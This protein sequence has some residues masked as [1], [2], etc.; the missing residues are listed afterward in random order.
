[1]TPPCMHATRRLPRQV[2][3]VDMRLV[4]RLCGR[5]APRPRIVSLNPFSLEDVL[6]VGGRGERRGD[7]L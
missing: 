2:C 6:Q 3:S 5:L 4:E 1:M 7:D